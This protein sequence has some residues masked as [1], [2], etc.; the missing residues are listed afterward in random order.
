[1]WDGYVVGLDPDRNIFGPEKH[2]D[3]VNVRPGPC[4]HIEG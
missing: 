2:M 4:G 1:M 3:V